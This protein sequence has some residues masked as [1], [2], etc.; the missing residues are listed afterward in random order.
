MFSMQKENAE[1]YFRLSDKEIEIIGPVDF[2][3]E[4]IQSNDRVIDLFIDRLKTSLL[5]PATKP[6]TGM[7]LLPTK[8]PMPVKEGYDDFEEVVQGI[9][10]FKK[11]ENVVAKSG[12]KIQI[13][14]P[15]PGDRQ[16]QRMVNVILIYLYL[17]LK[18][19]VDS[20]S[21]NEL[22]EAC[23]AH[24]ELD[25]GHFSEYIK[26]NKKIFITEGTGKSSIAKLTIPGI[27]EAER[28]LDSLN[29]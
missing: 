11:Y 17:K 20:V 18:S 6:D 12:E 2:V 10:V 19:N 4:Q 21:F 27:R 13:L 15:I 7:Q 24:A 9:D 28:I 8:N 3:K 1:A 14:L 22:R 26:T 16:T 25:A 29:N 5:P 23:Q